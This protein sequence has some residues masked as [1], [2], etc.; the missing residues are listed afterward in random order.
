MAFWLTQEG[1]YYELDRPLADSDV[2]VPKRPYKNSIFV[3]GT[4]VSTHPIE[5][6]PH[7][8]PPQPNNH[9]I[10]VNPYDDAG[11]Y[12]PIRPPVARHEEREKSESVT[13]SDNT[14]VMFGVKELVVIAS[15]IV[16]ATISWTDTNTRI[17]KLEESRKT[18]A[19]EQVK[20]DKFVDE[21]LQKM[22]ETIAD[23]DKQNKLDHAKA[24]ESLK[25]LERYVFQKNNK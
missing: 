23:N 8:A 19:E 15:F 9:R 13:L 12:P 7:H 10:R 2:S 25:E 5:D 1:Y 20:H 3:N 18:V 17:Q 11:F 22:T 21:K 16:T 6:V 24:D 14:K 4:W